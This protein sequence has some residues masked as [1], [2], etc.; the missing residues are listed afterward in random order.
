MIQGASSYRV[1]PW[2]RGVMLPLFVALW[3]TG[4]V[5]APR[6][7]LPGGKQ[8]PELS[9]ASCRSIVNQRTASGALRA[10]VEA[11]IRIRSA[12]SVSFRYGIVHKEP[13]WLRI[14]VLPLEGSYTLGL[15]T[16][17][18]GVARFIDTQE[19]TYAEDSSADA[20]LEH[21]LGLRGLSPQVIIALLEQQI[22]ALLCEQVSVFV[23]Q[24]FSIILD[25]IRHLSWTVS[26]M[27][28]RLEDVAILDSGNEIVEARASIVS[29][30]SLYPAIA[31]SV[32][33]PTSASAELLVKK[34]TTRVEVPDR[35]FD[36]PI[37]P[38]FK[39]VD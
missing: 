35:T 20:L 1:F 5:Q 30:R 33:K 12:E 36:I 6:M 14:D 25:P 10:I 34:L 11:T 18:D 13:A 28:S 17:K 32:Y 24:N 3:L 29:S 38:G 31:I 4:C 15:F 21:F 23:N 22:P 39:R 2:A 26:R 27:S 9:A 16:L 8:S 37:P 19:R 7:E